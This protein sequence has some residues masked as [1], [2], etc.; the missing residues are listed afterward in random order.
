MLELVVT[1]YNVRVGGWFF[2]LCRDS[3]SVI[4]VWTKL[5]VAVDCSAVWSLNLSRREVG[6]YLYLDFHA[7]CNRRR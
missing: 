3:L 1:R 7:V 5:D 4:V 6:A 2:E